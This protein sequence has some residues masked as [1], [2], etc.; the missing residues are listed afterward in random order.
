MDSGRHLEAKEAETAVLGAIFLDP[1]AFDKV[2]ETLAC[3]DFCAKAS[4][5]F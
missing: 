3:M 1:N 5:D 4:S 2:C